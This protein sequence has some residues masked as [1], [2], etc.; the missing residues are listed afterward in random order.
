VVDCFSSSFPPTSAEPLFPVTLQRGASE[1][2]GGPGRGRGLRGLP[3]RPRPRRAH[4]L[5]LRPRRSRLRVQPAHV[6]VHLQ[7]AVSIIPMKTLKMPNL[8]TSTRVPDGVPAWSL[9]GSYSWHGSSRATAAAS[10]L[11]L[12][13]NVHSCFKCT[14]RAPVH[15]RRNF[16]TGLTLG[17]HELSCLRPISVHRLGETPMQSCGQ[18]VS[19]PRGKAD[20]RLNAHTESRAVHQR[21]AR[22]AIY[23]NR[24][25]TLVSRPCA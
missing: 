22:R 12:D 16:L 21:S 1:D 14:Y 15:T 18:S 17:V 20:A 9:A 7:E 19:A 10:T 13:L 5:G 24:P 8:S 4:R 6:H 2:H 3:V 25:I 11:Q 23:R